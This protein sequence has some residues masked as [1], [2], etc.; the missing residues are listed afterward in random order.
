M[1]SEWRGQAKVASRGHDTYL[2]PPRTIVQLYDSLFLLARRS[3]ANVP[4]SLHHF[5]GLVG[6]ITLTVVLHPREEAVFD[7]IARPA[8]LDDFDIYLGKGHFDHLL[9][10]HVVRMEDEPG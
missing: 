3:I 5:V 9:Q 7:Q 4:V 6:P 1:M 8:I 2:V 10:L